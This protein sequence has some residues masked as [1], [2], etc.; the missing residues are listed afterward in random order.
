MKKT[1]L[2]IPLIILAVYLMA[3]CALLG[4]GYRSETAAVMDGEFPFSVTYE[5]LGRTETIEGV[6]VCRGLSGAKDFGE[7]NL[8][9]D[10]YVKDHPDAQRDFYRIAEAENAAI[11]IDLNLDP[12]YLMGAKESPAAG[13]PTGCCLS[14]E[15]G[16]EIRTEDPAELEALG[17]RLVSWEYPDPIENSFRCGGIRLSGQG[18]AYLAGLTLAALLA[19]LVLVRRESQQKRNLTEKLTIGLNFLTGLVFF[20]IVLVLALLNEI[21]PGS[22]WVNLTVYLLPSVT[23]AGIA[24]SVVLRR[25]GHRKPGL[26]VQ[27]AGPLLL[28]LVLAADTLL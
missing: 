24:A 18:A 13:Q 2:R 16:E 4:F 12:G 10:G 11:S 3:A 26:W 20:P 25:T 23:L 27:L 6:F 9:W 22:D 8:S 21:A 28:A 15:N 7:S 14:W 19:C 17:F 1:N 5:Y